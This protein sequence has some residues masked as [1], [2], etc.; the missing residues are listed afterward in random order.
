MR[1]VGWE[2]LRASILSD[3]FSQLTHGRGGGGSQ[4]LASNL[5]PTGSHFLFFFAFFG[6][7]IVAK[8]V[9]IYSASLDP[10]LFLCTKDYPSHF[11]FGVCPSSPLLNPRQLVCYLSVLYNL[12]EPT[13]LSPVVLDFPWSVYNWHIH[14]CGQQSLPE[15]HPGTSATSGCWMSS[16]PSGGCHRSYPRD[17]KLCDTSAPWVCWRQCHHLLD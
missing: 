5:F 10:A 1:R 11:L 6:G 14:Q 17:H 16:G 8:L 13:Y 2:S 7:K 3:S 9:P 4:P 15:M 12:L